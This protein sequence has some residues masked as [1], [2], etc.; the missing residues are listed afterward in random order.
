MKQKI[1]LLLLTGICLNAKSQINYWKQLTSNEAKTIL[2][3]QPVFKNSFEP[4]TYQLFSLNEALLKSVTSKAPLENTLSLNNISAI[5]SFP[6]A[7]GHLERFSI[8]EASVMQPA[9]QAKYSNIRS[10]VGRGINNKALSLRFDLNPHGLHAMIVTANR[11]VIYINSLKN[12]SSMYVVFN[13]K[14]AKKNQTFICLEPHAD[15]AKISSQTEQASGNIN[16]GTLRQYRFAVA[17]GAEFSN[18]LLNGSE[19][20]D[21]EKKASVM[22]VLVTDLVRINEVYETDF[23][24]RLVYVNNMDT[25]I[26]L[27]PKSDPFTSNTLTG[28][29]FLW[30]SSGQSAMN[31]NIGK[32]NYDI[33]HSL[34]GFP[35]GGNAGG[36]GSVCNNNSKGLG[37]TG[38]ISNLTSDPFIIDY[39]AH[40]I[41]HQFGANHT[42]DYSYEGTIAQIEPGSGSTI[43]GYAGTTNADVQSNSD[44][45]FSAASIQQVTDFIQG[46]GGSSC[47][48]NTQTSNGAL[49]VDAGK[50]YVIP[51]S[52]PFK[53]R[54]SGVDEDAGDILT[55][56]WEQI[57]VVKNDGTSS[58]FPSPAATT[59][60]VFRSL[61]PVYT[62]ER[63][64][65][66]LS[67]ILDGSNANTWEVL[68]EVSRLLNFRLTARDNHTGGGNTAGDNTRITVTDA[69]GPFNITSFNTATS[70]GEGSVQ[71]INW[72]V[73]NT[74]IAP[75]NCDF[76]KISLSI[77]G[78]NSFPYILLANTPNDG[79]ED[80]TIPFINGSTSVARI[81]IESVGNIF[82]DIN[83]ADF[84][85][86]G[87]LPVSWLSFT[88]EKI[89]ARTA[90]LQ[91]STA[92]E[93]N[94]HHFEIER[95]IN[96]I[97]F[98]S[99]GS[100]QAKNQIRNNYSFNDNFIA[101]GINY[102]RIKQVD[103]DGRFSYSSQV[104]ITSDGNGISFSIVPNPAS[105]HITIQKLDNSRLLNITI[106]DASGKT[107]YS[108]DNLQ[109]LNSNNGN[110]T[111]PLGNYV[112]GTY[113]IRVLSETGSIV[114]KLM[115]VK[116]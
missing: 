60:P 97:N 62:N 39:W 58:I 54:G 81:K 68:P 65:P 56:C 33:G 15:K 71:T 22:E 50:D 116:K 37:V 112:S 84:S 13:R 27:D 92:N 17:T 34:V 104:K 52:T 51:A 67:S 26:Y 25:I 8:Y 109:L 106:S 90:L 6:M 55:Y 43:M 89:G 24:V 74:N 5:I 96:G 95:S 66:T 18:L 101:A 87:T 59:G 113:F 108:N 98:K 40:E 4:D 49:T 78:G 103:N 7:D 114:Q 32:E 80:I 23:G 2:K 30:G 36:L 75:V 107:V 57:D 77:D 28:F 61:T 111:I 115:V 47:S 82:F 102:Y 41:G 76:V 1:V 3:D 91:W 64:F 42:F 45:Y 29:L 10:Y 110:Y 35:T 94:N 93:I 14:D 48:V 46:T 69:A 9:L 83:N 99:I 11:E 63:T 53:L 105:D 16:D 86:D 21:E 79:A 31:K 38:F 100:L 44:P 85:I 88:A 73:A 20:T 12:N 70:I 72:A 19:V